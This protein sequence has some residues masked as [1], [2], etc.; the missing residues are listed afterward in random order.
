[1]TEDWL[2]WVCGHFASDY[3]ELGQH[4][5]R[6]YKGHMNEVHGLVEALLS[7]ANDERDR[8]RKLGIWVGSENLDVRLLAWRDQRM[9]DAVSLISLLGTTPPVEDNNLEAALDSSGYIP[10]HEHEIVDEAMEGKRLPNALEAFQFAFYIGNVTRV[11]T[12]QLV[13]TRFGAV[14]IQ[15][16]SRPH[17][18]R[19]AWFRM[20]ITIFGNQ[21]ARESFAFGVRE[22]R[23]AYEHYVDNVAVPWQDARYITPESVCTHIG[24]IYTWPALVELCHKRLRNFMQWETNNVVR[25][26]RQCIRTELPALASKLSAGCEMNGICQQNE[27]YLEGCGKFPNPY[28]ST[29]KWKAPRS[30]SPHGYRFDQRAF[31]G[32]L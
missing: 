18:M 3:E 30:A 17:D 29:F 8:L 16:S 13:R 25:A 15:Q 31:E 11:L 14:F 7:Q 27:D 19:K 5:T 2:C 1:M 22:A 6:T 28:D 9:A 20:P 4:P 10:G 23:E 12:H 26:M 24:A 21:D 32:R